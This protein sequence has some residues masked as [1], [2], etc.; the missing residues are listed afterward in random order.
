M[1][2]DPVCGMN[3]EESKA[4]TT[5]LYEGRTYYFCSKGC[6]TKFQKEPSKYAKA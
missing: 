2:K 5:S 3:V 6:Q 1:T 4:A